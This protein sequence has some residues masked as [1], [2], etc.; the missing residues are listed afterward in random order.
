M[1]YDMALTGEASD[2]KVAGLIAGE[3]AAH[4]LAAAVRAGAGLK[5]AQVR[6]L[7]PGDS[8]IGRTLEPES[9]GI[10][11]TIIRA[12]MWLALTGAAVGTL[13]FG[14]MIALGVQ[15]IVLSP[16]LSALLLIGFGTVAG[17]MLG[18]A[19]SLRPDHSPYI[20]ASR[21]ALR[22]GEYVVVV[23]ATSTDEL[24]QAEAILK[25]NAGETVRTL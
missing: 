25:S 13:A 5:E 4:E 23:H 21:E 14:V 10:L 12:H 3:A 16:W 24:E 19:V 20:A 6:V 2:H 17:L 18:G 22:R 9:R 8:D 1:K 15:F 7:S 11:H